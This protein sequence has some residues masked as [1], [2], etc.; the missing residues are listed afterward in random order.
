MFKNYGVVTAARSEVME[1]I[2][3]AAEVYT[4]KRVRIKHINFDKGG[5]SL[6]LGSGPEQVEIEAAFYCVRSDDLSLR[7]GDETQPFL[8]CRFNDEGDV[9]VSNSNED[10]GAPIGSPERLPPMVWIGSGYSKHERHRVP[11]YPSRK[12]I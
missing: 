8:S 7:L 9:Q 1:K 10:R 11:L 4:G 3:L 12:L 6:Y 5:V 2:R